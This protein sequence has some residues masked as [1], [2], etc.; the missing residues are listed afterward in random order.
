MKTKVN[1]IEQ[2]IFEHEHLITLLKQNKE[3]ISKIEKA[4]SMLVAAIKNKKKILVCGNGGSAA[5]SQHLAGELVGR[6][7]KEREPIGCISLTTN[8]S[9]ITAI[10][11][12][13]G[14]DRIFARQIDATGKNGDVVILISTSGKSTN[15]IEAAKSARMKKMQIISLTGYEPNMLS[16]MS[17]LTISVPSKSTPRIQEIHSIIIHLICGILEETLFSHEK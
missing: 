10:G 2:V 3:F 1:Q 12:D 9:I 4:V 13:Y 5:D 15:I 17:D 6:F 8:T 14:F 7:Q 16:E 11:N